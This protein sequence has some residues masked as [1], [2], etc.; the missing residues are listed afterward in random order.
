MFN[1][2]LQGQN[3]QIT[4]N[5]DRNNYSSTELTPHFLWAVEPIESALKPKANPKTFTPLLIPDDFFEVSWS[6]KATT[7]QATK[8]PEVD[9]FIW[10]SWRTLGYDGPYFDLKRPLFLIIDEVAV[11]VFVHPIAHFVMSSPCGLALYIVL[12]IT[13]FIGRSL[14]LSTFL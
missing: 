6:V 14:C 9:S 11:V 1:I 12:I 2:S 10:W 7:L 3:W 8:R 5:C 13:P 4:K